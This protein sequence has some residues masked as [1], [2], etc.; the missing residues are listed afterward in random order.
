VKAVGN[1]VDVANGNQR[2]NLQ[3]QLFQHIEKRGQL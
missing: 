2:Q 1:T 3:A